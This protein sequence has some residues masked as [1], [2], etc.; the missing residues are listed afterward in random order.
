MAAADAGGDAPDPDETG[1]IRVS[2]EFRRDVERTLQQFLA[3][4]CR[5]ELALP[6]QH[7]EEGRHKLAHICVRC[8]Q[9]GLKFVGNAGGGRPRVV[10]SD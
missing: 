1:E 3:D 9:L 6:L 5:R 2:D 4:P 7:S 8:R 10:K